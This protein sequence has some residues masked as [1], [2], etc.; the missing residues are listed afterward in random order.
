MVFQKAKN[1]IIIRDTSN[2][3]KKLEL[4]LINPEDVDKVI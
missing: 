4:L 3:K 1:E 2:N